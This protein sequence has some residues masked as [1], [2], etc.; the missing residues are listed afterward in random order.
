VLLREE[1]QTLKQT[2]PCVSFD[3]LLHKKRFG[4]HSEK[5][6]AY[7][8]EQRSRRFKVSSVQLWVQSDNASLRCRKH[9]STRALAQSGTVNIAGLNGEE[10]ANG[11]HNPVRK[12]GE[13]RR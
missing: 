1:A 9:A 5:T 13:R 3:T 8:I 6:S 4:S 10:A 11:Q 2:V 12:T 7:H